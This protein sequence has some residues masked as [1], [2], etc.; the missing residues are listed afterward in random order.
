MAGK[1]VEE[2]P[3]GTGIQWSYKGPEAGRG[4]VSFDRRIGGGSL[5]TEAEV[6][7]GVDDTGPCG[8]GE[9]GWSVGLPWFQCSSPPL[10]SCLLPTHV[11]GAAW[12]CRTIMVEMT[13]PP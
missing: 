9:Q 4:L 11:S 5:G 6:G 7:V 8:T 13:L 1:N 12:F 3:K 2:G 10:R